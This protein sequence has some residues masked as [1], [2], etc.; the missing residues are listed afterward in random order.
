M[1][2]N[3]DLTKSI[4][5]YP[6]IPHMPAAGGGWRIRGARACA[7]A[8]LVPCASTS[9][10]VSAVSASLM[11]DDASDESAPNDF[12]LSMYA[13][14]PVES[15]SEPAGRP[16][17]EVR[18]ECGLGRCEYDDDDEGVWERVT[19]RTSSRTDAIWYSRLLSTRG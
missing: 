11:D 19:K 3:R 15:N 9:T 12:S 4:K 7:A 5:R 13:S 10:S 8:M 14:E 2:S 18:D 1:R 6:R 16:E 17:E